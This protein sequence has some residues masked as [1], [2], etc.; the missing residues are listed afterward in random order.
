MSPLWWAE[1]SLPPSPARPPSAATA[2]GMCRQ[3][4]AG[5]LGTGRRMVQRVEMQQWGQGTAPPPPPQ[6]ARTHHSESASWN[7]RASRFGSCPGLTRLSLTRPRSHGRRSRRGASAPT[8]SSRRAGSGTHRRPPASC[9]HP[10]RQST[11]HTRQHSPTG[12]PWGRA[13]P[14]ARF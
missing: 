14:R 4:A 2:A 13:G 11:A 6:R 3:T 7:R 9:C 8:G 12:A 5:E 10:A 1:P